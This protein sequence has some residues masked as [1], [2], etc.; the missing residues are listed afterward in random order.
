MVRNIQFDN[1]NSRGAAIA[2]NG[3]AM[4]EGYTVEDAQGE[5]IGIVV[6]KESGRGF[7]FFSATRVFDAL[8]GHIFATAE[9]AQRAARDI[10]RVGKRGWRAITGTVERRME[11]VT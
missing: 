6:R 4:S 9:A 3:R 2:A 8:D 1:P 10:E 5:T 11:T 7:R